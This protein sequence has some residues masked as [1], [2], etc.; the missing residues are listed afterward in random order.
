M[1]TRIQRVFVPIDL[2]KKKCDKT[3]SV[4][5]KRHYCKSERVASQVFIHMKEN[6][7]Q[8]LRV[9]QHTYMTRYNS[10]IFLVKVVI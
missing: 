6:I 3:H 5:N 10:N 7:H 8:Y 1:Y 4:I 2:Q 9:F